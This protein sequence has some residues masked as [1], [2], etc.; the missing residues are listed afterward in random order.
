MFK[1]TLGICALIEK[2]GVKQLIRRALKDGVDEVVLVTPNSQLAREVKKQ[3]ANH[4]IKI[5]IENERK[6][7]A[8]AIN[9]IFR[10]SSGDIIL[11]ASADV[12]V[13]DGTI[14]KLLKLIT[15]EDNVGIVDS[16]VL[17]RNEKS[18]FFTSIVNS[19]WLFHNLTMIK[20]NNENRLGHV[21]GDLYAIKRG[22]IN[23]IPEYIINDDAFIATVARLKGYKVLHEPTAIC[24]ILGPQNPYDYILQR[25]RVLYG[26]F[27]I[28]RYFR[29]TPTTFEFT[30]IKK[31]L[32]AMNIAREAI[33]RIGIKRI[34]HF[35]IASL[36]EILSVF[37]LLIHFILLRR[38]LTTWKVAITTKE[39]FI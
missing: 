3:Y 39:D 31:P 5:I 12:E 29:R 22:V 6:G 10:N 26:H 33:R 1:I 30:V 27:Q 8:K 35:F 17:L 34:F 19:A 13:K 38:K 36:L 24:Y 7:K 32:I 9:E 21:A 2:E 28:L 11:M 25:S 16:H 23:E 15:S 20:L 18:K 14:T 37:Y 4:N